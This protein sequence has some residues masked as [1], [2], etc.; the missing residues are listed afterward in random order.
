MKKKTII[1]IIILVSLLVIIGMISINVWVHNTNSKK[2]KMYDDQIS[3]Y[4]NSVEKWSKDNLN[5][6]SIISKV[7][8]KTL[9]E[10]G[11]VEDGIINPLTNEA[12]ES[13]MRFCVI[14]D[15]GELKYNYDDGVNCGETVVTYENTPNDMHNGY[16]YTQVVK[17]N[18][19]NLEGLEY[20]VKTMRNAVTNTNINYSCGKEVNPLS[21]RSINSTKNIKANTWYKVSGD[22]EITYDET[23]KENTTLYAYVT[24][25]VKY[26]DLININVSKIDRNSP[27][28]VLYNPVSTTN[29][30]SVNIKNMLDN[31]TDIASSICIYGTTDGEYTTVS[32]SNTRGK[33]SKCI[34]NYKLKDKTYYYQVCAT[35]SVGNVGC[36][37]G[38][39]LI[40]SVNKP[41]IKYNDNNEISIAYYI[42]STSKVTLKDK[43]L[44]YCGKKIMPEE[45]ISNEINEILPNVWY[46]VSADVV[47]AYEENS[48]GSLYALIYNN[49]GYVISSTAKIN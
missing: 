37:K 48:K 31:E 18:F 45:C 20:Y 36:A 33:L 47:L 2:Q 6:S 30:I 4:L 41:V 19:S 10:K 11:Y 17:I 28:V 22:I 46:K 15:N 42:K 3:S 1:K 39:S 35:D 44:A 40:Q 7:T 32:M 24:D 14:N 27:I 29:S 12:F 8:L 21:C 34:I 49:D 16:L 13:S 38:S 9:I 5:Q 25:N 23:D 26:K 43:T